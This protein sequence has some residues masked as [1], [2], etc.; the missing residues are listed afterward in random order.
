AMLGDDEAQVENVRTL[1]RELAGPDFDASETGFMSPNLYKSSKER[2]AGSEACRDCHA[3]EFEKLLSSRHAQAWETLVAEETHVDPFCQTCHTTGYGMSGGF[4][5]RSK[6][7]D[8]V[9]VGCESCH[10]P[11]QAHVEKP[12]KRTAF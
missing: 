10:G 11:S 1:R 9:A 8:R 3:A 6:S 7:A 5:S 4:Q 2:I 12:E